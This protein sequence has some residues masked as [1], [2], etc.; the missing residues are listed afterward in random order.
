MDGNFYEFG[1][2]S[3]EGVVFG[4][5]SEVLFDFFGGYFSFSVF[6]HG[7]EI[8][9]EHGWAKLATEPFED[10]ILRLVIW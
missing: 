8:V 4:D 2:E 5:G 9:G 1:V 6:P 3:V 7:S 10:C